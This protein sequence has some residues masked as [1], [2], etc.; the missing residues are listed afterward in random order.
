MFQKILIAVDGSACSEHAGRI[1]IALAGWLGSKV[2]FVSVLDGWPV[3]A[4]RDSYKA[5][6]ESVQADAQALLK[7]WQ[8]AAAAEGLSNQTQTLLAQ[9]QPP[10]EGIVKTAQAEGCDLIVMGTHSRE[11]FAHLMLGSVA[12]RVVRRATVP[13]LLARRGEA[14]PL[15]ERVMVSVDGSALSRLAL[16]Q[17]KRLV[18]YLNSRLVVLHVVPQLPTRLYEPYYPQGVEPEDLRLE[19]QRLLEEATADF[20]DAEGLLLDAEGERIGDRI[21]RAASEQQADLIVMGTHG[22]T[23][24]DHWLLGSVAERVVHRAGCAVL[25]IREPRE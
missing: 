10:A 1:G 5:A 24:L 15:F 22:R 25:L 3:V 17:A 19:G 9:W 21:A 11:G 16:D 23:G 18:G 6:L 14:V 2:L 7:R 20:P 4:A 13:V 12:E 8:E